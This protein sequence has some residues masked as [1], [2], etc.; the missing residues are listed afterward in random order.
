MNSNLAQL[1]NILEKAM[2]DLA[3]GQLT[4][5]PEGKWS[6]AEILEHLNLS[7]RG[8][9]KG[10]ERCLEA[11]ATIASPDRRRK[12]WQRLAVIQVG[13]F[14]HGRKSPER[15][16]PRGSAPDKVTAEILGNVARM[17]ALIQECATRFGRKPLADHPILGPLTASEW[18]KFHLV[19]GKHH[20]KQLRRLSE[21][22]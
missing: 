16:L 20:A 11:N 19:H 15:V 13:Y 17:D 1:H 2:S 7:Y 10:L 21:T 4:R 22:L 9:I 3:P 14:P 8:T 5:H 18:S 6:P 12:R